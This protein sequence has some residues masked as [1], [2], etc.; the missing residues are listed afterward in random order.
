MCNLSSILL[1]SSSI[2]SFISETPFP[3]SVL[4]ISPTISIAASSSPRNHHP[5]SFHNSLSPPKPLAFPP[6]SLS[7]ALPSFAFPKSSLPVPHNLSTS[8]PHLF[9][10][11]LS[12]AISLSR[13]CKYWRSFCDWRM[14]EGR[15]TRRGRG[16]V[17]GLKIRDWDLEFIFPCVR[18]T[19]CEVFVQIKWH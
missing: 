19:E 8:L 14:K 2:R 12:L 11:S 10:V 4:L 9:S 18:V 7:P 13:Y 17:V 6:F 16:R 15:R 3:S 5:S 1:L